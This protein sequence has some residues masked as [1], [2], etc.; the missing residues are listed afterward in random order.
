MGPTGVSALNQL[1][2]YY[3]SQWITSVFM[4]CYPSKTKRKETRE[5]KKRLSSPQRRCQWNMGEHSLQLL[6]SSNPPSPTPQL[7]FSYNTSPHRK[8]INRWVGWERLPVRAARHLGK[9]ASPLGFPWT[10]DGGRPQLD[11]DSRSSEPEKLDQNHRYLS[12]S[13]QDLLELHSSFTQVWT[14]T[15]TKKLRWKQSFP[16]LS[17]LVSFVCD[18]LCSRFFVCFLLTNLDTCQFILKTNNSVLQ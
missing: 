18:R 1:H 6:T 2:R 3:V 17:S 5:Q 12:L 14:H 11:C 9:Q 4:I 13:C 15:H 8:I 7:F 10:K 16:P